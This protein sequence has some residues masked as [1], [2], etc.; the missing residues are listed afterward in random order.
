MAAALALGVCLDLAL[1]RHAPVA[2]ARPLS[3]RERTFGA[4]SGI[5]A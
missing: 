2:S 5:T 4:F 3:V 1:L